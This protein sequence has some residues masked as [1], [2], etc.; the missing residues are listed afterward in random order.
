MPVL[1][2]HHLQITCEPGGEDAARAFYSGL[3]GLAEVEKPQALRSRGGVWFRAGNLEL[4]IG[5]R[6][7]DSPPGNYRHFALQVDDAAHFQQQLQQAGCRLEAA[8][9]VPG[10]R[11]FFVFDPFGNKVEILELT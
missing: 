11:R 9:E 1:G 6:T 2:I 3:L 4:H 8:P 10:W 7:G 5:A